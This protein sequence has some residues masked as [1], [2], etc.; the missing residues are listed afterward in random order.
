MISIR[1]DIRRRGEKR[2]VSA[3]ASTHPT[4]EP[5]CRMGS[6]EAET[7][8]GFPQTAGNPFGSMYFED[9]SE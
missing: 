5:P 3:S 6:S 2:W 4:Q 9:L 1:Q 7:H 8:H